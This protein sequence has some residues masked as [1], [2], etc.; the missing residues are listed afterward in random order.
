MCDIFRSVTLELTPAVSFEDSTPLYHSSGGLPTLQ[1][2]PTRT[3]ERYRNITAAQRGS[4]SMQ[5]SLGGDISPKTTTEKL[6]GSKCVKHFPFTKWQKDSSSAKQVKG[7]SSFCTEGGFTQMGKRS[8]CASTTKVRRHALALLL[9]CLY[10]YAV[11]RFNHLSMS[12][13]SKCMATSC[14]IDLDSA[15]IYWHCRKPPR[16]PC[17]KHAAKP[18]SLPGKLAMPQSSLGKLLNSSRSQKDWG[19]TI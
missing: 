5:K 10:Y 17:G 3:I 2:P 4:E 16:S 18:L 15:K 6:T 12:L 19:P 8:P 7:T 11:V 1:Y 9:V 14:T 13:F